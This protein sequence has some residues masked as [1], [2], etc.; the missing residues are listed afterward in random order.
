MIEIQE[1][2][3]RREQILT[4]IRNIRT[5]RK[6]SVTEQFLKTKRKGSKDLVVNGPY[7]L[8]TRKEKGKSVG[9]RLSE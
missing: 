4:E 7:Y 2:E 9:R 1:L 5:M 8:Y 3:G 6:G